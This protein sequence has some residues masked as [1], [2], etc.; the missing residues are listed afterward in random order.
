MSKKFLAILAAIV[1]GLV[2]L[3]ALTDNKSANNGSSGANPTNH[4]RGEGKAN[5]TLLEYGDYQCSVCEA[6]EPV[7]EQVIAQFSKDIFFQFRNLPLPQIH[8][9]AFAASRAA[10]AADKQG[11]FWEMHDLLYEPSNWQVWTNSTSAQSLFEGYAQQLGLDP[12]KF[13]QDYASEE[14]NDLINA[15]VA[16]FNKTGQ[17]MSTPSFFIDGKYI[18]NSEL[19][20]NN[21][22]SL[23]KFTKLINDAINAKSQQ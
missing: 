4:V 6:Y 1:L 3:F 10:E 15:D 12:N 8:P 19:S 13:K 18:E 22:P 2:L 23:E 9:N 7:V 20:V 21:A 14:V 16:E 5:V 11:K 17:Q